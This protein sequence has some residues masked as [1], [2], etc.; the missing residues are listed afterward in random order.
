MKRV[1][2]SSYLKTDFLKKDDNNTVPFLIFIT[3]QN[4]T[5]SMPISIQIHP[6]GQ[7]KITETNITEFHWLRIEMPSLPIIAKKFLYRSKKYQIC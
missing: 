1:Q 4:L 7:S 2:I 5:F 6:L 3:P